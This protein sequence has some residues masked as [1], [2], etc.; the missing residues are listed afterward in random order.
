MHFVHARLGARDAGSPRPV[1]GVATGAADGYARWPIGL[2]QFCCTRSR[3]GQRTGQPPQRP[4]GQVP[5]VNGRRPRH[6]PRQVRRPAAVRH[7][8]DRPQVSGCR[9]GSAPS[10]PSET[11]ARDT[12]DAVA[13]SHGAPGQVATLIVPADACWLD[14]PGPVGPVTGLRSRHRALRSHRRHRRRAARRR[15]R[16]AGRGRFAMRPALHDS[17]VG[18]AAGAKVLS[19]TFPTRAER[20]QSPRRSSVWPT[21]PS[22]PRCNSRACV[23]WCWSTPPIRRRSS[24]YPDKASDLVRRGLPGHV[25]SAPDEGA[26]GAGPL[27]A[28]LGA[29][30]DP[31]VIPAGRPARP[32]A[33]STPSPY[34]RP[35]PC[36]PGGHR[37]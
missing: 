29:P 19:E 3:P 15:A 36:C 27:A 14:S 35:G 37:G 26:A 13:A 23:T 30:S 2:P 4:S 10:P 5:V 21:W 16:A 28:A 7:H 24:P 8:L 6:V 20:A 31:P 34:P 1:R 17:G 18:M 25:L 11:I 32:P 9:R 12:A 22:S 33:S